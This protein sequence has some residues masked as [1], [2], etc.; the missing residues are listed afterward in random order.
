MRPTFAL[1]ALYQLFSRSTGGVQPYAHQ[2]HLI[3][4]V[5]CSLVVIYVFFLDVLGLFFL[6]FLGCLLPSANLFGFGFCFFS[7]G[8]FSGV[9]VKIVVVLLGCTTVTTC[10]YT[11]GTT[12]PRPPLPDKTCLFWNTN[13][14]IGRLK[15]IPMQLNNS[16]V[17]SIIAQNRRMA[18]LLLNTKCLRCTT[19]HF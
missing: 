4:F 7:Y 12:N 19:F 1:N 2:T 14:I 8:I 18:L 10:P 15:I 16:H 5:I 17:H 13:I 9:S 3:L 11:I 6:A